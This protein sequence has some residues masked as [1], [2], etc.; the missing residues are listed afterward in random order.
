MKVLVTGKNSYIGNS[1]IEYTDGLLAVQKCSLRDTVWEQDSWSDYDSVL[2]VA[3]IAHSDVSHVTKEEQDKYYVVNCDLTERVA[4][5][6]KAEG[7][8]QFI[9]LS[10]SIVYGESAPIG[11]QKVINKDT[12]PKPSNFYGDSKL[13]AENALL[14]LQTDDFRV[15]IIRTP[16]VYGKNSKG[17]FPKLLHLAKM[18]PIF[19]K[20]K[21]Q[22]SM[23]Y[24]KNLC[25]FIKICI[26]KQHKGIYLP[27]NKEL[28]ATSKLVQLIGEAVGR[29]ILLVPGCT[30]GL[31][32]LAHMTGYVNKVFGNLEY[33]IADSLHEWN[34]CK[35][36]L[37]QSIEEI[38]K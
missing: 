5:K 38:F 35:Y 11:K 8:K 17:N 25:E 24:I 12:P 4:K 32:I 34:Y 9:Y 16:M 19:P 26:D 15:V 23:I 36:T 33:E 13:Q 20:I 22:R 7:V 1:F 29:K 28:V 6:A 14:S 31:K 10:S 3:G 30:I 18:T 27:Q 2:H 37:E 21:N